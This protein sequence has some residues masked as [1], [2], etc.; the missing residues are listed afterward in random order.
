M[1]V[2]FISFIFIFFYFYHYQ[3]TQIKMRIS[4][5]IV[6]SLVYSLSPSLALPLSF[7][8]TYPH[9]N[10]PHL[11]MRIIICNRIVYTNC[12]W[13]KRFLSWVLVNF[14]QMYSLI[15]NLYRI[16]FG[17]I[18][19]NVSNLY[20]LVIQIAMNSRWQKTKFEFWISKNEKILM[21]THPI[22]LCLFFDKV[23]RK[24]TLQRNPK[25][26]HH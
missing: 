5:C 4:D 24:W 3:G 22:D 14:Q 21:W 11:N 10:N 8:F 6:F 23:N 13:E 16:K 2:L 12:S 1:F 25:R 7:T 26:T 15:E 18:V 20:L 19:G 9:A 17:P